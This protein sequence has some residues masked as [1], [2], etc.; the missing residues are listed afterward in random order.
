MNS[1]L[2]YPRKG[3]NGMESV[4]LKSVVQDPNIIVGD[5]TIYNDFVHDPRDFEK[6]NVLY[7]YSLCNKERKLAGIRVYNFKETENMIEYVSL[8]DF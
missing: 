3:N 2:I 4:Y 5:F 1:K 6:N 8:S 7:H